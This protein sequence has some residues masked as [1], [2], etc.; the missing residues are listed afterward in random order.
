M[1][2]NTLY[3]VSLGTM[4]AITVDTNQIDKTM[5]IYRCQNMLW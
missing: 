4:T 2:G 1:T 5:K 3:G